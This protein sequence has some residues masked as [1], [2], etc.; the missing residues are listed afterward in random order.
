MHP[1]ALIKMLVFL[2]E[3]PLFCKDFGANL[4]LTCIL[5]IFFSMGFNYY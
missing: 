3:N 2:P 5:L 4:L 1:R